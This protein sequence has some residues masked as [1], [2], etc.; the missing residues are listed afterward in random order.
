[1][2]VV[3]EGQTPQRMVWC[4]LGF[5]DSFWR[6]GAHH[7]LFCC[8]VVVAVEPNWFFVLFCLPLSGVRFLSLSFVLYLRISCKALMGTF[9]H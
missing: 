6:C 1:M 2:V 5:V 8:F 7:I 4:A 9:F 3:V